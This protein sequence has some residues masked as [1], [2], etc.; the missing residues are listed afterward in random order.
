MLVFLV[1]MMGSGK[2]TIGK[3]LSYEWQSPFYDTDEIIT[4][5]EG[6]SVQD[7]FDKHGEAYFRTLEKEL[8]STWK[9][10]NCI[11]ATGGGLPCVEGVMDIM[12]VK[13]KTVYLNTKPSVLAERL[14]GD[15]QRPLIKDLSQKEREIKL[16]EILQQREAFY[17]VAKVKIVNNSSPEETV[18]KILSKVKKK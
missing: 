16:K 14:K 3:M 18:A 5:I 9:M 2:T 4:S 6:M 12:N 8:I 15:T 10:T 11:V 7:I 1:G 17:K 13:G